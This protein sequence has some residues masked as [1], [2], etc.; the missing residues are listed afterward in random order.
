[1]ATSVNI[2][3][4]LTTLP[5]VYSNI[6]SGVKNPPV[7]LSYGNICIIDTGIGAGFSGLSGVNGVV[8]NGA[9]SVYNFSTIQDFRAFVKGGELWNLAAPLFKPSAAGIQGVSKMFYVRAATTAPAVKLV[10]FTNGAITITTKDEGISANGVLT[11][12]LLTSGYSVRLVASLVSTGSY[13]L[14]FYQGSFTGIDPLNNVPYDGNII[15]NTV[16]NIVFKTP[17]YT[18]VEDLY[19]F[20]LTDSNFNHL[21]SVTGTYAGQPLG[22][23]ALR[24]T[25]PIVTADLTALSADQLFV[26]GTESFGVN[27]LNAALAATADIDNTFFLLTEYGANALSVNNLNILNTVNTNAKYDKFCVFAG[28]YD[29]S[30]F[31]AGTI[32]SSVYAAQTLNTDK[33]IVIHGGVK[34]AAVYSTNGFYSYSQLYHAA[35]VLGRLAGLEPQVP[36]TFKALAI[37]GVNHTLTLAQ[38]ELANISGVVTTNYDNELGTFVVLLDVNTLQNNA[39][40]INSDASSFNIALKRVVS[41]LNKEIIYNAKR[42][43]FGVNAGPN[44]NTISPDALK[45]WLTGFLQTKTASSL[46][47]NLIL[48][49]GNIVVTTNNDNVFC[50]YE[51]VANTEVSKIIFSG[52]LLLN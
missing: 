12:G 41:Q 2:N 15:T 10:S 34:K 7:P 1:M 38:K 52:T 25:T 4:R 32:G 26:G 47:D 13:N 29:S 50:S 39:Y 36:V 33:A 44:R 51:F 42:T 17:D 49:F 18:N 23:L 43:F 8:Q 5:G 21:F 28:G 46:A 27:D 16:P 24:A 48:R 3:G 6:K 20:M 35:C 37:D 11:S 19:N 30:T 31:N 9:S 22:A 45:Q 14:T 40:L